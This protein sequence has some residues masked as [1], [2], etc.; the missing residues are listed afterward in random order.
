MTY[1]LESLKLPKL[2]GRPLRWLARALEMSATRKMILPKLLRDGGIDG[3]RSWRL[4]EAP[5][6]IPSQSAGGEAAA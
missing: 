6:M 1:N 3:L 2:S 5:T 4:D